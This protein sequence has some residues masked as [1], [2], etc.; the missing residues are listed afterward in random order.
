MT[1]RALAHIRWC[2]II[3]EKL[4]GKSCFVTYVSVVTVTPEANVSHVSIHYRSVQLLDMKT[5]TVVLP[6]IGMQEQVSKRCA[7]LS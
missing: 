2:A 5:N 1:F 7:A 4:G 6:T 3:W